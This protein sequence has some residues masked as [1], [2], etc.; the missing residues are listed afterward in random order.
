MHSI[1]VTFDPTFTRPL[2]VI[3]DMNYVPTRAGYRPPAACRPGANRSGA[4]PPP[5]TGKGEHGAESATKSFN[6][7]KTISGIRRDAV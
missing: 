5:R 2:H 4:P 1:L 7:V 3:A 6:L